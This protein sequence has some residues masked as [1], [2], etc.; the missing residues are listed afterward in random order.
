MGV[1]KNRFA[2]LFCSLR[3]FVEYI[4]I[5]VRAM[6]M[7]L[8]LLPAA[9]VGFMKGSPAWICAII[10]P[11]TIHMRAR[12]EKSAKLVKVSVYSRALATKLFYTQ[13]FTRIACFFL[14][15]KSGFFFQ[16]KSGTTYSNFLHTD[17]FEIN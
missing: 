6:D 16:L 4:C 9:F 11:M 12:I 15:K 7:T 2:L 14:A 3:S 10:F 8:S 5:C 1:L 13:S 17:V